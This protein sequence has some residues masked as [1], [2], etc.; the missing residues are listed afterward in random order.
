VSL[1]DLAPGTYSIVLS[2][3]ARVEKR[4]VRVEAG[5]EAKV[6]VDFSE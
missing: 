1:S 4:S 6:F 3:G 2:R 5:Q